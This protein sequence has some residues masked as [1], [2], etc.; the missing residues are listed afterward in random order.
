MAYHAVSPITQDRNDY[1]IAQVL[2]MSANRYRG[3]NQK[4]FN[5][6]DFMPFTEKPKDS[7]KSLIGKL[8]AAFK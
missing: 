4:T 8:K 7:K 1:M 2:A 6:L 3:K 5:P